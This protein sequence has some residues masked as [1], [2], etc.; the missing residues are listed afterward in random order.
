MEFERALFRVYE[1]SVDGVMVEE[2]QERQNEPLYTK[3]CRLFEYIVVGSSVFFLFCLIYLHAHVVGSP[4]CLADALTYYNST[5]NSTERVVIHPDTILGINVDSKMLND[6]DDGFHNVNDGTR[7]R[8]KQLRGFDF[9]TNS[10]GDNGTTSNDNY[11]YKYD[12]LVTFD[13]G[14]TFLSDSMKATHGFPVINVSF[15]LYGDCFGGSTVNYLIPV[16][17]FDTVVLNSVIYTTNK[18]GYMVTRQGEIHKWTEADLHP[19]SKA[20]EW[21][22]Y[23][24]GIFFLSVLAFFFISTCTALLVRT[25]ISSGIVIIFPVIWGLQLCGIDALNLRVIAISYP[26]IGIPLQMIRTRQQAMEPFVIGHFTRAILYYILY[27]A[28]QNLFIEWFYAFNG[29]QG[30][31]QLFLYAIVMLWEYFSMI[32]LRSS[33]S[34][35]V[36]PRASMLMFVLF[37]IYFYSFSSGFHVLALSV[38]SL[39][40]IALMTHCVR[41]YETKAYRLGYITLD[42]P[43]FVYLL[44]F[45]FVLNFSDDEFCLG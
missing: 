1:R 29:V 4:G 12:Y 6:D 3:S 7:R 43:R 8:L 26:W 45:S 39:L 24:L 22:R 17:G 11:H 38:M 34:I 23:K 13:R 27:I 2:D 28:A 19:Y 35:M 15:S 21:I 33:L 25:L 10:E 5:T 44:L 14:V 30:V 18:P 42:Q 37:H 16:G 20:S 41:V 40:S 32:Y 36:F 9:F 31:V